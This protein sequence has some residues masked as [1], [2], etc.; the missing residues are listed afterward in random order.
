MRRSAKQIVGYLLETRD[1]EL[2]R[3]ESSLLHGAN[4]TAR[5]VLAGP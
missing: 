2:G 5:Y 3:R 4:R 1:G